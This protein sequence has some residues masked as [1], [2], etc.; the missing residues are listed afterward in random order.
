VSG[1][2]GHARAFEAACIA[3]HGFRLDDAAALE[4]LREWN[5][6][7]TH[8]NGTPYPWSEAELR[9][10]LHSARERGSFSDL[11][12]ESPSHDDT[13]TQESKPMNATSSCPDQRQFTYTAAEL[14]AK[15]LGPIRWAV[16]NLLAEGVS[17]FAGKPKKG[18]SWF[19]LELALAVAGGVSLLDKWVCR[20]GDVL[21]LALEDGQRRLQSRLNKLRPA[22]QECLHHLHLE[23]NWPR[24][25]EASGGIKRLQLWL[26]QHPNT[27]LII[28]DTLAKVRPPQKSKSAYDDDYQCIGPIKTLADQRGVAVLFLTHTCKRRA[29]DVFDTINATLGLSGA[30]DTTLVL[31]SLGGDDQGDALLQVTGRDVER[32]TVRMTWEKDSARW[33]LNKKPAPTRLTT[34]ERDVL[35]ALQVRPM[36]PAECGERLG[37][38]EGAMKTLFS[39]M[40]DRELLVVHDGEYGP[41]PNVTL[42]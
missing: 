17:L 14:L 15:D 19:A 13:P 27:R 22:E 6:N 24:F 40:K 33:S 7:C 18:K 39:R 3:V 26:N 34:A 30:A 31:E 38:T 5:Q 23:T 9:H 10:K 11:L 20:R 32:Q 37:K 35:V 12:N 16:E 8:A 29:E 28:I 25:D 2:G 41:A 4:L 21:Y 1:Q 42:G 36:K